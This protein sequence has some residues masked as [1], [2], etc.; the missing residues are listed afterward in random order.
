MWLFRAGWGGVTSLPPR[1]LD[2]LTHA[3]EL[4]V[5]LGGEHGMSRVLQTASP[6]PDDLI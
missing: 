6:V 5:H 1:L 2:L 3:A 4:H